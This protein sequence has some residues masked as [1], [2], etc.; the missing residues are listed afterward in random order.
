MGPI[1]MLWRC[2]HS[3]IHASRLAPSS[4]MM[5]NP[6]PEAQGSITTQPRDCNSPAKT[7]LGTLARSTCFPIVGRERGAELEARDVDGTRGVGS[8]PE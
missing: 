5:R 1:R 7:S 4:V 2:L 8:T 3:R 6:G